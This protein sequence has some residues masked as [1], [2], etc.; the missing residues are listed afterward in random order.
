MAV[1]VVVVTN[2]VVYLQLAGS[3]YHDQ[4]VLW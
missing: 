1:F 2:Q 4:N 3:S